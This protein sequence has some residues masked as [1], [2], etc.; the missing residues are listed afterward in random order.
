MGAEGEGRPWVVGTV[1]G[2]W[3]PTSNRKVVSLGLTWF[4]LDSGMCVWG[5]DS[6]I[7]VGVGDRVEEGGQDL[8]EPYCWLRSLQVGWFDFYEAATFLLD[9]V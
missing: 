5:C 2:F 6:K 9:G 7:P 1:S 3:A 4:P 8:V